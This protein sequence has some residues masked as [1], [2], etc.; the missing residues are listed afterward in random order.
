MSKTPQ[1]KFIITAELRELEEKVLKEE[2]SYSM[3]IQMLNEK[4]EAYVMQQRGEIIDLIQN[5]T[6]Y[7]NK[8]MSDLEKEAF[9]NLVSKIDQTFEDEFKAE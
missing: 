4:A 8:I 3:M 6:Y 2:I 9:I 5:A 1:R 7:I